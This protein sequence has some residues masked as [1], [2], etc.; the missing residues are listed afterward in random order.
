[1][2]ANS[3]FT[4]FIDILVNKHPFLERSRDFFLE[5]FNQ[6]GLSSIE[7]HPIKYGAAVSLGNRIVISSNVMNG[8][9]LPLLFTIFHEIAHQFQYK[10]MGAEKMFKLYTGEL[11]PQEAIDFMRNVEIVADEYATRKIRKMISLGLIP[12]PME[13]PQGF[14]K[15]YTDAQFNQIIKMILQYL[16][17]EDIS[18]PE[19]I[20]EIVFNKLKA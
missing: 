4:N 8:H 10:K 15:H 20:S 18:D 19:R 13:V 6:S 2:S 3:S 17:G 12:K 16:E 5:T 1:M 9:S 11:S 14:Y 7:I